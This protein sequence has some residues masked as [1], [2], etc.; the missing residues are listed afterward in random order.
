MAGFDDL[1]LVTSMNGGKPSIGAP[2]SPPASDAPA[3]KKSQSPGVMERMIGSLGQ[4]RE[5]AAKKNQALELDTMKMSPPTLELSKFK[6]PPPTDPVEAWGSMAMVFAALASTRVRNHA[7]TAMNAAA[8]AL[9]A[10]KANDKEKADQAFKTW[11][12]ENK[13]AV[14]MAHFQQD[15]YKTMLESVRHRED[16]N[17]EEG[18]AFDAKTEAQFRAV[19]TALQDPGMWQA[20]EQGGVKGAADFQ[21]LRRKQSLTTE[22][23]ALDVQ[24]LMEESQNRQKV[25]DV[26]QDPANKSKSPEE[27]AKLLAPYGDAGEKAASVYMK[28]AAEDRQED[29][30][31]SDLRVLANE[32]FQKWKATPEGQAATP[33]QEVAKRREIY[34][35]FSTTRGPLTFNPG[36]LAEPEKNI[37][38]E[39]YLAYEQKWPSIQ[40]QRGHEQEWAK[41]D[42]ELHAVDPS[43]NPSK[44]DTVKN[45]RN[46]LATKDA[47]KISTFVRLDQ[48][49]RLFKELVAKLPDV[50]DEKALNALA[51]LWGRQTGNVNVSNFDTAIE[52]IADEAVKAATGTSAAGALADREALKQKLNTSMS[53]AQLLGSADTLQH[54]VGGAMVAVVNPYR[55]VLPPGEIQ[56]MTGLNPNFLREYGVDPNLFTPT[57]TGPLKWGS[58]IVNVTKDGVPPEASPA[59]AQPAAPQPAGAPKFDPEQQAGKK[60]VGTMNGKDVFLRNNAYVFEDGSPAQ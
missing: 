40:Q 49:L 10:I 33:T 8:S 20:Y 27:I 14:E 23:N 30:E 4:G 34:Q 13:N 47:D 55:A 3:E 36:A 41:L 39:D 15:A 12:A 51:A 5:E 24:K 44:F 58:H 19:T 22:K 45:V 37:L 29:K 17:K 7:T 38:K 53:K 9:N 31:R 35:S 18:A 21:E 1:G 54:L 6:A 57:A 32:D 26:V 48:H 2:P 11:E 42:E 50:T 60:R 52:L 25:L 46:K 16:V 56:T 59:D 28:L 43:W